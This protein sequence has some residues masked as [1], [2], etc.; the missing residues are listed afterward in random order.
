MA[1]NRNFYFMDPYN[2]LKDSNYHSGRYKCL[3]QH[4][5]NKNRKLRFQRTSKNKMNNQRMDS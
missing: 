3:A 5:G 2:A 4:C 1:F